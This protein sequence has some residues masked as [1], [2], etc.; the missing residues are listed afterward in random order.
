MVF[1]GRPLR[2]TDSVTL[3]Q[4]GRR[5]RLHPAI[6]C[7]VPSLHLPGHTVHK[8]LLLVLLPRRVYI[9][10]PFP[11]VL[12][13]R[14]LLTCPPA[15]W[16]CSPGSGSNKSLWP[17]VSPSRCQ[18]PLWSAKGKQ[19]NDSH[20]LKGWKPHTAKHKVNKT[21]V[22]GGGLD[23]KRAISGILIGFL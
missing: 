16:S 18:K 6:K 14:L 2:H 8:H 5:L 1:N 4:S 15:A 17:G 7:S 23:R 3:N 12:V 20:L 13:R 21:P 11:T 9:K 22:G 19:I 10:P